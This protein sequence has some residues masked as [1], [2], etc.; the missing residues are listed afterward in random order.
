MSPD[1]THLWQSLLH[2]PA[3]VLL[4]LST[5]LILLTD[6]L[7]Q[8]K[9][10]I[11]LSRIL[12]FVISLLSIFLLCVG[13]I[14]SEILFSGHFIISSGLVYI[15][16]LLL[17]AY[18]LSLFL[19]GTRESSCS[20]YFLLSS[21]VLGSLLLCTAR[22]LWAMYLCIVFTALPTYLL[23]A[24]HGTRRAL[25]SALKYALFGLLGSAWM[26]YGI[27]LYFGLSGTG[28]LQPTHTSEISLLVPMLILMGLCFKLGA[29]P[30]HFWVLS[31]YNS[32]PLAALSY[33]STGVK[34]AAWVLT[35]R[36]YSGF[37]GL[38]IQAV[39]G[40]L[41]LLSI[42]FGNAVALSQRSIRGLIAYSSVAYA[43]LFMLP[44][45]VPEAGATLALLFGGSFYIAAQYT[46]FFLSL[47]LRA[48]V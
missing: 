42:V 15:K 1:S 6:L 24:L 11:I 13:S 2:S 17:T 41:A 9:T 46:L 38:E 5:C 26:L 37:Q 20:T 47:S 16:I 19:I 12:S 30:M 34:L 21:L 8:K 35:Y 39:M 45:L 18:I 36:L 28:L 22:S 32:M 29:W 10:A 44:I 33:L 48:E 4:F 7:F 31:M 3:E 27:S 43:G 25:S 23:C 40:G 14:D